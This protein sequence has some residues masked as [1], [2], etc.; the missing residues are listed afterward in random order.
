MP[1]WDAIRARSSGHFAA[2]RFSVVDRLFTG[3]FLL[4]FPPCT[5]L[6][7]ATSEMTTLLALQ[8]YLQ[9]L[10]LPSLRVWH[11]T[12]LVLGLAI[13]NLSQGLEQLQLSA[14]RDCCNWKDGVR[15]SNRI[16][17]NCIQMVRHLFLEVITLVA[18]QAFVGF[19]LSSLS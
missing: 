17:N 13:L 5:A 4:F 7:I 10:I 16:P 19:N 3:N 15:H 18:D 11:E 8:L 1:K 14:A 6:P 12:V 9:A 2:F